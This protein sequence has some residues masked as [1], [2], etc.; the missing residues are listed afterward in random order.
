MSFY[1]RQTKGKGGE[2]KT[3]AG[4]DDPNEEDQGQAGDGEAQ[5]S[6][7]HGDGGHGQNCR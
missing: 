5:E 7:R 1:N 4:G 6:L 3:A 2:G